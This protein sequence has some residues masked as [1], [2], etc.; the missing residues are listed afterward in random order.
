[1]NIIDISY[2]KNIT[3]I[4]EVLVEVYGE[5]FRKVIEN[6][7]NNI[8]YVMYTNVDG[9][10][11]Y[12]NFLENCKERELSFKFL[13]GIGVDVN[14]YKN[15]SYAKRLD[16]NIVELMEKY[17][18]GYYAFNKELELFP[19]G[20]RAFDEL[21]ENIDFEYVLK[22]QIEFLNFLR[23][24]S[25]EE[26]TLEN[27]DGFKKSF[28]YSNLLEKINCYLVL[29]RVLCNELQEY[30]RS[31]RKYKDFVNLEDERLESLYDEKR[32]EL[33]DTIEDFFGDGIVSVLNDR[34]STKDERI[35]LL[36]DG[37]LDKKFCIEYFSK[38]M[39]ERLAD[40][41]VSDIKKYWIYFY[42]LKY[43]E[44]LGIKVDIYGKNSYDEVITRE[45]VKRIIPSFDLVSKITK[46]RKIKNEQ[47]KRYFI[48]F[49]K[50]FK[51]NMKQFNY[52]MENICFLY[53]QIKDTKICVSHTFISK[54]DCVPVLF[55]SV[56]KGE[57]GIL[58]Y[59]FLHEL[60]HAIESNYFEEEI[61]C[62]FEQLKKDIERN[63][64]RLSKRKY[65]RMNETFTD[66]I[67]IELR[68]IL[69]RKGIYFAEDK[70]YIV[71]DVCDNNTHSILK[72]M[73]K[74]L[75]DKYKNLILRSRIDGDVEGFCDI[76]GRD[77]YE[78][79]NDAI[80]KVDYL[81]S[82]GLVTK[83]ERN[84]KNDVDVIMYIDQ[85]ER[86]ELI[87]NNISLLN[88]YERYGRK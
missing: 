88:N 1:M 63:P 18:G 60:V 22:A 34:C 82:K 35:K 46:Y 12:Y 55:Y 75:F 56:R 23:G 67:A 41:E 13:N 77:N 31:I 2:K 73:L 7:V 4:I 39:E 65:E 42:R 57:A 83:L 14:K 85:L 3:D 45:E 50:N 25:K 28:E 80:N 86:V 49:S 52:T 9:V 6:K 36:L 84:E 38:E 27:Y 58:D 33:Y 11:S 8:I 79:L 47:V 40:S 37:N 30:L 59:L 19:A 26:I 69:H 32:Q 78:D 87:Y 62:G 44:N 61:M 21:S 51:E 68:D 29:Y 5:E 53:N 66:M 70:K 48:C 16:D 71:D 24:D 72:D 10:R 76:I 43:L 64:Y 20:I 74:P 54:E 17:I 15:I 81:L